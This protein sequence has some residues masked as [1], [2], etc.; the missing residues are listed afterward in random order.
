MGSHPGNTRR[1]LSHASKIYIVHH[2]TSSNVCPQT[3][4]RK[5]QWHELMLWPEDMPPHALVC[6][7]HNDDLVPSP[8]VAKHI[9]G[10]PASVPPPLVL[11]LLP[12]A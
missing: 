2:E 11:S 8:F 5:F 1:L 3:F 4:C 12:C 6:L 9:A 7:S 10:E